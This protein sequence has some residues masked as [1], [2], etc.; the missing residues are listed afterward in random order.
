MEVGKE[1]N[2]IFGYNAEMAK[3]MEDKMFFK[4]LMSSLISGVL[5][6]R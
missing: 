1:F 2:D 6:E 4:V 3:V 5:T